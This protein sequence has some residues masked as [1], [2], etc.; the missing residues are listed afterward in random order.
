MFSNPRVFEH[1]IFAT[2]PDHLRKRGEDRHKRVDTRGGTVYL[3]SFLEGPSFDREGNLYCVNIPFGEIFRVSPNGEFTVVAQYRGRPNGLKIHRDGRIFIADRKLMLLLLDPATGSVTPVLEP[4]D[5][6]RLKGLNDLVFDANGDLY[7]TDFEGTGLQSPTG[8]VYR[9]RANGKLECVIDNVPGPNGIVLNPG[10]NAIYVAATFCNAIW[11]MPLNDDGS[12]SRVGAFFTFSGGA[13]PD[14]L[15]IDSEGNLC[16]AHAG[17]G[18]VWVISPKGELIGA[19]RSEVGDF[20]TNLAYGGPGNKTLF[21]M[22]ADSGTI[23]AAEMP[24]AGQPMYSH[25]VQEGARA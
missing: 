20:V 18:T 10:E 8:C 7:F 21:I 17:F 1:R 13:G 2:V 9:L 3:D 6:K 25:R 15:A 14:G 19:V 22:E 23:L 12:V 24:V 5:A 16:V 11:R 4:G